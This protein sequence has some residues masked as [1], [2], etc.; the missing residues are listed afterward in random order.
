MV[1]HTERQLVDHWTRSHAPSDAH[2]FSRLTEIVDGQALCMHVLEGTPL[3][4]DACIRNGRMHPLRM[5]AS[6]G[7]G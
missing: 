7:P 6:V 3:P 2:D 5:H 1:V 4:T